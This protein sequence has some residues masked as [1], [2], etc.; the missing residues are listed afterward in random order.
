MYGEAHTKCTKCMVEHTLSVK[1][2]RWSIHKVYSGAYTECTKL[3]L[4]LGGGG[5]DDKF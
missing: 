5:G 1:S 2:V 3:T 4:E